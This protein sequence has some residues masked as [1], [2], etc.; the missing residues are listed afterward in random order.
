[1]RRIHLVETTFYVTAHNEQVCAIICIV[2]VNLCARVCVWIWEKTRPLLITVFSRW[3]KYSHMIRIVGLLFECRKT[4]EDWNEWSIIKTCHTRSY[5]F[6]IKIAF[7]CIGCFGASN[8][9][10]HLIW[11]CTYCLVYKAS[12]VDCGIDGIYNMTSMFMWIS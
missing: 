3:T 1:M 12:I 6:Q 11:S 9:Q 7:L 2:I 10:L 8:I 4:A 5:Q